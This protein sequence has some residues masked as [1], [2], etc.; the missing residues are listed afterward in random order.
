MPDPA[1]ERARALPPVT[2][3]TKPKQNPKDVAR[4]ALVALVTAGLG[5]G[6][7]FFL[8]ESQTY[9]LVSA[10]PPVTTRHLAFVAATTESGETTT[11]HDAIFVVIDAVTGTLVAKHELGRFTDEQH[12]LFNQQLPRFITGLR[13][14]LAQGPD[15]A[16]NQLNRRTLP[17]S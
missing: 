11:W 10:C 15:Q 6:Y 17:T 4:L 14:L 8:R 5:V 13:L 9:S 2:R 7:F 12:H 16:M 1:A 3:E